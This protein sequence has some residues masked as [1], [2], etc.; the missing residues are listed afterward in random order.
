MRRQLSNEE[1]DRHEAAGPVFGI[2][3]SWEGDTPKGQPV[4]EII[5]V[6]EGGPGR[7]EVTVTAQTNE[8]VR[9][10]VG[11]DGE[12]IVD[13]ITWEDNAPR[14]RRQLMVSLDPERAGVVNIVLNFKSV[15]VGTG[16][17]WDR[18][19]T[20]TPKIPFA[21]RIFRPRGAW[22]AAED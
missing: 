13:S 8:N 18:T 11:T 9:G 20:T 2:A 7:S 16:V 10:L 3:E 15:E 12:K 19:E 1:E 17:T 5:V 14:A 4:A 22:R 6:Q 21:I